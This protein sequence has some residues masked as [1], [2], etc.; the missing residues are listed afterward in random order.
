MLN[1]KVLLNQY[2]LLFG[3]GYI[4]SLLQMSDGTIMIGSFVLLL[5]W[6]D[7]MMMLEKLPSLGTYIYLSVNV[8]RTV[9][10]FLLGYSPILLAFGTIFYTLRPSTTSFTNLFMSLIKTLTMMSGE[11]DLDDNFSWDGS[12]EDDSTLIVQ[13]FFVFFVLF[14]NIVIANLLIGKKMFLPLYKFRFDL[15]IPCA[16]V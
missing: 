1:M 6:F 11:F 14:V 5:I 4:F 15:T 7:F 12:K 16:Q 8:L 13:L 2:I 10:K 9:L 3:A